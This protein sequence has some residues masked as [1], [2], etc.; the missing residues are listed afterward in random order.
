[1]LRKEQIETKVSVVD[2]EKLYR[3]LK[4]AKKKGWKNELEKEEYLNGLVSKVVKTADCLKSKKDLKQI[5]RE[6]SEI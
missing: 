1:M 6:K 2:A 4:K 3:E 5:V